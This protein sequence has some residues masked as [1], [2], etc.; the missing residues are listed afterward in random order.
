MDNEY[1]GFIYITTNNINGMKYIGKK[2]YDKKE[3]W[4][5]YLGSGIYLNRAIKKY[6]KEN[7]SKVIIEECKTESELN[8][9]EKYWIKIYNAVNNDNFYNIAEGGDGGNVISGYSEEQ[10][11]KLRELHSNRAKEYIPRG[12]DG[13]TS[14]L[15]NKDVDEII[16]LLL[17]NKHNCDI[18]KIYNISEATIDDIRH[19]RTWIHK[20]KNIEFD[21]A[22]VKR[23]MNNKPVLQ[24]SLDNNFIAEYK[25][26]LEAEKIT[27]IGHKM[28]SRVCND[29]RPHTHGYIFKFKDL[30]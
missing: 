24:Y 28:I 3:T 5:K 15:S 26:A 25:S 27:G 29:G 8:K 21:K 9:K 1:Y 23:G 12:E 30:N 22:I 10:R 19:H 20:T 4:K 13:W 18:A 6:G 2:K 17:D 11:D 16:K 7:F 14:K